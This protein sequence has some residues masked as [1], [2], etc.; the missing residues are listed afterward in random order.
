MGGPARFSRA[1]IHTTHCIREEHARIDQD[2]AVEQVCMSGNPIYEN[3]AR[4]QLNMKTKRFFPVVWSRE[5][6]SAVPSRVSLL[7]LHTE[8]ESSAHVRVSLFP[9]YAKPKREKN[10]ETSK[11]K[12]QE[13][14]PLLS[15]P[16]DCGVFTAWF[17]QN[18]GGAC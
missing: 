1:F 18:D 12:T 3:I 17:V 4:G 7:I 16:T 6:G 10:K 5:T 14:P 15:A 8:A 2:L 11:E 9:L 13:T